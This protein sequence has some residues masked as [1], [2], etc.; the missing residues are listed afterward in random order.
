M[1][2]SI[3]NIPTNLDLVQTILLWLSYDDS[4]ITIF[5][6]NKL[7]YKSIYMLGYVLPNTMIKALQKLC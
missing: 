1:H 7:Q 6:K 5:L 2:G 3:V 4:S